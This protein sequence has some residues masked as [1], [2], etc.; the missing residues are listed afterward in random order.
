[1]AN[2]AAVHEPAY[3]EAQPQTKREAIKF[4]NTDSGVATIWPIGQ[5][6]KTFI[7]AQSEDTLYLIDQHAAHER[8]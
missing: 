6:D 2:Q 1:M 3:E 4:T 7:I 5:V 8:I